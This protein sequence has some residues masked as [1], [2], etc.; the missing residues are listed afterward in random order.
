MKGSSTI[1]IAGYF[2]NPIAKVE[3]LRT[4]LGWFIQKQI[5]SLNPSY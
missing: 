1:T 2:L 4:G 5:L 3:A